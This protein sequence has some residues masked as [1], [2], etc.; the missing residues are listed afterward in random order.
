MK[1]ALTTALFIVNIEG[2]VHM[3]NIFK[4]ILDGLSTPAKE[5]VTQKATGLGSKKSSFGQAFAE[6]RDEQGSGGEFEYK[7][8]SYT[9]N[10]AEENTVAK[11]YK[12]V[13]LEQN[14]DDN[15][16]TPT[17]STTSIAYNST[18]DDDSDVISQGYYPDK[19]IRDSLR[20]GKLG[21]SSPRRDTTTEA[22]DDIENAIEKSRR[23]AVKNAERS[24]NSRTNFNVVTGDFFL[25]QDTGI[26]ADPMISGTPSD[27]EDRRMYGGPPSD[28]DVV[29]GDFLRDDAG[30][31]A[32]PMYG[33]PPSDMGEPDYD[34]MYA[35]RPLSDRGVDFDAFEDM[36]PS[37][38]TISLDPPNTEFDVTPTP[39][40]FPKFKPRK[41]INPSGIDPFKYDNQPSIDPDGLMKPPARFYDNWTDA[42]AQRIIQLEGFIGEAKIAFTG[43]KYPTVGYGKSDAT[44]KLGDIITEADALVELKANLMPKKIATAKRLF[45]LFDTY[46]PNLKI[47]LLQGVFRGNFKKGH[48]A[49]KLINK[50]E[51]EKASKEFLDYQE[52]RDAKKIGSGKRGV[53]FRMDSISE[54]LRDEEDY[55]DNTVLI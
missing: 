7:G 30:V 18:S 49:V 17:G 21:S 15:G 6:A 54:A 34:E 39:A 43:E 16:N 8:K 38:R 36:A 32:D 51:W 28:P 10:F 31:T 23:E 3:G 5:P 29:T 55:T 26:T 33:G 13:V 1:T 22:L 4:D 12:A 50:G 48:E 40:F 42:A 25:D 14:K 19:I 11:L 20:S 24:R 52:Y 41:V 45:P 9:T 27:R 46:S 53:V 37:E 44:V 35:R 47:E 2:T